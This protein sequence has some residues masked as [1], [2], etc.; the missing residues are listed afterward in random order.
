M[1]RNAAVC[2]S[3][4]SMRPVWRSTTWTP[5]SRYPFSKTSA[6]LPS[7]DSVIAS[8]MDPRSAD[9]PAGSSV[10]PVGRRRGESSEVEPGEDPGPVRWHAEIRMTEAMTAAHERGERC[11]RTSNEEQERGSE[12]E[13]NAFNVFS[14]ATPDD[15][16][17]RS[18]LTLAQGGGWGHRARSSQHQTGQAGGWN[19]RF[20]QSE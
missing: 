15:H 19:N 12:R 5:C 7:G 20:R 11:T 18:G 1:P 16:A 4:W 13:Q 9:V 17:S 2:T 3:V 14:R 6:F 8:G 10:R